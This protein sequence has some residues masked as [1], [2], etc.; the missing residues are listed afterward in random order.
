MRDAS[1][2]LRD[3]SSVGHHERCAEVAHLIDH[4]VVGSALYIGGHFIRNGRQC[5]ADHFQRHWINRCGH[6]PF[7][8]EITSSPVSATASRSPGNNIV[9]EPYSLTKAGPLIS[10][11]PAIASRWYTGHSNGWSP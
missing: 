8:T 3:Q 6:Y 9:V 1:N 7:P 2:I 5:V 11:P 10:A 4:H